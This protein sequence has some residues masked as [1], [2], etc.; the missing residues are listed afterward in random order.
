MEA[1][2]VLLKMEKILLLIIF[3]C[4][5][6]NY[7]FCEELSPLKRN[8]FAPVLMYHDIRPQVS[9]NFDVSTEDFKKQLDWLM[10]NGYQTL[11]L[12][13]YI[14]CVINKK[15]FPEKSVL[16]T[17]DDG[18]SGIYEYAAPEL[19]KRNMHAVFFVIRDLIGTEL[20]PDEHKAKYDYVTNEQVKALSNDP[21][22]SI[23]S[24]TNTH[25][26]P[27][28]MTLLQLAKEYSESKKYIEDLTGKPCKTLA[29]PVGYYDEDLLKLAK[30]ANYVL[31]FSVADLGLLNQEARYS[32]P[33]IY[34]GV[35]MGRNDM[36]LFKYS[37]ENYHKLPKKIF[38]E[39]FKWLD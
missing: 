33:R 25:P 30:N 19:H 6:T 21:L 18:Y 23:G 34:M 20:P 15:S 5:F 39:R 1:L 4:F 3:T 9:N 27:H 35:A 14:D 38:A 37:V 22:F 26:M 32:I 31:A 17:F 2:S 13:A 36:K 11:S 24:H 8:A 29:F 10:N 7:A 16:I 28:Q 12:D